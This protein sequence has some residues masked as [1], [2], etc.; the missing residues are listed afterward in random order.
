MDTNVQFLNWAFKCAQSLTLNHPIGKN[1]MSSNNKQFSLRGRFSFCINIYADYFLRVIL[2]VQE[3]LTHFIIYI[4][5]LYKFGQEFMDIITEDSFG[6][7]RW[8]TAYC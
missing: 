6:C 1:F 4:K 5:L 3:V 7:C 8:R 2:Y